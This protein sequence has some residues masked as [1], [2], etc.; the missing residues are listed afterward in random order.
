MKRGHGAKHRLSRG[1]PG[2]GSFQPNGNV[3]FSVSSRLI[4]AAPIPFNIP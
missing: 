4:T 1:A 3:L 2:S